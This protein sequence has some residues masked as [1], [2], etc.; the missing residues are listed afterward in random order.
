MSEPLEKM[1][2][3]EDRRRHL[4]A[5]IA[6]QR[7]EFADAYRNLHKPIEIGESGLRAFGFI[8][9]N[10]WIFVAVPAALKVVTF[11]LGLRGV[12]VAPKRA[13]KER[14]R[15]KGFAGYAVKWGGHGWKLFKIYRRVRHYFS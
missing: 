5:E 9:Q 13:S 15:P 12:P 6:R 2:N 1:D 8:R 10:A 11:F 3:L 14:E 7:T 4:I